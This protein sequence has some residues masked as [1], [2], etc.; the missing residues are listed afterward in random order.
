[1][2]DSKNKVKRRLSVAPIIDIQ[3]LDDLQN[4]DN[5][6]IYIYIFFFL[7]IVT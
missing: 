1:M 5:I 3:I 4:D 2:S 6:Y 7:T